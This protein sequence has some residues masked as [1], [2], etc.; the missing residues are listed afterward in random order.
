MSAYPTPVARRSWIMIKTSFVIA[1]IFVLGATT[2]AQSKDGARVGR[3]S[4]SSVKSEVKLP[5][6]P[7]AARDRRKGGMDSIPK[8]LDIVR[9]MNPQI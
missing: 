8:F 4:D 5:S 3:A 2:L 9:S 1:A 7:T 6:A